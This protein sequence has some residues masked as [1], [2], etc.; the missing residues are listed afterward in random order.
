[1]I[2][3]YR[4]PEVSDQYFLGVL[5]FPVG[6]YIETYLWRCMVRQEFQRD[7]EPPSGTDRMMAPLRRWPLMPVGNPILDKDSIGAG[8]RA[9]CACIGAMIT[10]LLRNRYLTNLCFHA[11]IDMGSC[12]HCWGEVMR[13]IAWPCIRHVSNHVAQAMSIFI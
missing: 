4:N 11:I 5:Y 10:R 7:I 3:E 12:D 1:M 6:T 9:V 2:T 13:N 8:A